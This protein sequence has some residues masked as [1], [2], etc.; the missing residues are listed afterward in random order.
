MHPNVKRRYRLLVTALSGVAERL[1]VAQAFED[2]LMRRWK[3]KKAGDN[4]VKK[5]FNSDELWELIKRETPFLPS[6][7]AGLVFGDVDAERQRVAQYWAA[8]WCVTQQCERF[9]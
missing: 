1:G 7:W 6:H 8:Q 4:G 3:Q 5:V 2:E 9:C